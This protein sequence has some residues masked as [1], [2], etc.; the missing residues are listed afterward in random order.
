MSTAAAI[1]VC[2][3]AGA[4]L[5]ALNALGLWWTVRRLPRVRHPV[6]VLTGTSL[7]RVALTL[8]PLPLLAGGRPLPLAVA[9][10][11]FVAGRTVLVR[12]LGTEVSAPHPGDGR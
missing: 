3:P 11:A 1:A 2:V 12:R 7:L 10:L 8:G 9:A 5:G 4:G 6:A